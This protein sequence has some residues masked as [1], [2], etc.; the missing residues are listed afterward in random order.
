MA[1]LGTLG[2]YKDLGLLI[3]RI[4]LGVMMIVHGFPKIMGGVA[5]WKDLGAS[6]SV[7]GIHF[8]PVFWGFMAAIAEGVGGLFLIIGLWNRPT[9]LFLAFT[10]LVAALVHLGK[11]DGLS[12]ASHAIELFFVFI[13]LLFVGPGKYAVDKK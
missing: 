7:L 1:I 9:L 2:K 11:G 8:L 3:M 13:G 4:G 12:G 5:M 6:M 10:M